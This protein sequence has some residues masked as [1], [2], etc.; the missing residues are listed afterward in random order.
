[1]CTKIFLE[2]E[3]HKKFINFKVKEEENM[4]M[5]HYGNRFPHLNVSILIESYVEVVL[6]SIICLFIIYPF[7]M[8]LHC[9][10]LAVVIFFSFHLKNCAG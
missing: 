8:L 10:Q 9:H 4:G 7:V 1:M 3:L 6:Y 5:V 2:M